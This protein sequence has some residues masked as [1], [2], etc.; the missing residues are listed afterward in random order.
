MESENTASAGAIEEDPPRALDLEVVLREINAELAGLHEQSRFLNT[1]LD[2]M[3][4]ENEALRRAEAQ[5]A[6]PAG[7]RELIKLADDWRSRGAAQ[8][9][10]AESESTDLARL[11]AEIV[12]DVILQRQGVEEFWPATGTAFDRK[13]HRAVATRT[14]DDLALDGTIAQTRRPGYRVDDRVARFA[15]VEVHRYTAV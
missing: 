4:S 10:R 8:E 1:V 3:H 5:R 7:I 12:E 9:N 6:L 11:C 14:T 2:R 13:E 15:E